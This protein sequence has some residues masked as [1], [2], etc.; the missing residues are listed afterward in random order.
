MRIHDILENTIVNGPGN[1]ICIWLQ[2]CRRDCPGCFNQ[3]A[4]S[5]DG[6]AD[7][8]VEDLMRRISSGS[9]DGVSFSGGEPFLQHA[10]LKRLSALIRKAG[11]NVLV[12]TGFTYEEI[13]GDSQMREVLEYVDYLVDGPYVR[14]IPSSCSLTGSGNQRVLRLEHGEI[15]EDMTSAL[16][17]GSV[18]SEIIIGADG[19]VIVTGFD[20]IGEK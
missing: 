19:K 9:Y 20:S 4:R 11:M 6:G 7:M 14:E 5:L 13:R 12:F 17:D 15:A 16:S 2:G 18:M 1:R 8:P 3:S 10:E